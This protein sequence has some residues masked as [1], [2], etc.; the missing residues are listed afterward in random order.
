MGATEN[1]QRAIR[2]GDLPRVR[3]LLKEGNVDV[4]K[5]DVDWVRYEVHTHHEMTVCP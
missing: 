2:D 1:F 3:A 4:N 5:P